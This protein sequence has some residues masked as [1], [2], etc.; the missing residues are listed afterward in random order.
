M[1]ANSASLMKS[2]TLSRSA[3]KERSMPHPPKSM[4][5][6]I[7][8]LSEFLSVFLRFPKEDFTIDL[9]IELKPA[10]FLTH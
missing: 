9:N 4:L 10:L 2:S 7:P 5:A 1:L 3:R 6:N 8:L